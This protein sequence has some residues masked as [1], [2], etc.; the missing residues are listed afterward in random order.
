[1]YETHVT[2]VGNVATEVRCGISANGHPLARFRLANTARRFDSEKQAWVDGG[3][4]FFTVWAWRTLA[5][6]VASS[7]SI[8]QPVI[9][10]GQL[11]VKEVEKEGKKFFAADVIATS[12]GHDLSRG[13]A[14]FV[15]GGTMRS[16]SDTAITGVPATDPWAVPA[17]SADPVNFVGVAASE[18]S[19]SAE[20]SVGP[21]GWSESGLPVGPSSSGKATSGQA[22]KEGPHPTPVSAGAG[23][24]AAT[25]APTH[26]GAGAQQT[27]TDGPDQQPAPTK[28]AATRKAR[29]S[30]SVTR[31][32]AGTGVGPAPGSGTGI[33]TK[34]DR[35]V[36]M[37]LKKDPT[38]DRSTPDAPRAKPNPR[39]NKATSRAHSG[40]PK[41]GTSETWPTETRAQGQQAPQ[42]T[43]APASTG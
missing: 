7:V 42:P 23:A 34:E 19:K 35:Y 1:M 17:A 16:L 14:A 15:R 2:A 36:D 43:A 12:V 20:V 38:Q 40:T 18:S 6:N 32:S 5:T 8:G 29:E 13:T 21:E 39:T 27:A 22:A 10:Q 4:N 9:V 31:A 25:D 26:A 11:R 30:S 24:G 41:P 33:D 37:T 28:K 3:T